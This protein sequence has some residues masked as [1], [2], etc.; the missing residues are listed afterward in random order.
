MT[1]SGFQ[2][3]GDLRMSAG[4]SEVFF[5]SVFCVLI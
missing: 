3:G 1:V 5:C 2:V 4:L